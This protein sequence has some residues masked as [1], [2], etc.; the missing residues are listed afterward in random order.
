MRSTHAFDKNSGGVLFAA[1][2]RD[3]ESGQNWRQVMVDAV[4]VF[5]QRAGVESGGVLFA[6]RARKL[7]S[8][9]NW[10]GSR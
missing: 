4:Q 9:E 2:A 8:G 7:E 6:A 3:P 5:A 1:R 10:H